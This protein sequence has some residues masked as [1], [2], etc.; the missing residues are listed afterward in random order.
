MPN[1]GKPVP[2]CPE[3]TSTYNKKCRCDFC[4]E[5]HRERRREHRMRASA[6]T[7]G[8]QLPTD[9]VDVSEARDLILRAV[10][11]GA[12]DC[13]IGRIT[14]L[15]SQTIWD[16]RHGKRTRIQRDTHDKIR[17][18][19][20][21]NTDMR[22]F[23]DGT[24]VDATYTLAMIHGLIA[25]GWP[26]LKQRELIEQNMGRPA[27]FIRSVLSRQYP[28]VHYANEQAMRWLVS[29]IGDTLGPSSRSRA[30]AKNNGYFPTK[31][32]DFNGKLV[33][34]SLPKEMRQAIEGV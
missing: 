30:W 19:L 4:R 13:E 8:E 16:L 7:W 31:H 6:R 28:G 34:S 32:Y 3:F 20:E 24:R 1:K 23:R 17:K 9:K 14:G 26:I 33:V 2:R 10:S 5:V 29:Q 27:G 11:N 21:N 12:S 22:N 18:A 15:A 25:Q